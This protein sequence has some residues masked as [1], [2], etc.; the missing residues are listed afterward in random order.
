MKKEKKTKKMVKF[1]KAEIALSTLVTIILLV[2]GFVIILFLYYQINWVGNINK[3]VCHQSVVYRATAGEISGAASSYVPLKCK[4]DKICVTSGFWGGSCK[5]FENSKGVSTVKVKNKE[6]I[7]QL[8]AQNIVDC[9]SMMGEGRVSLFTQYWAQKVGVGGVYPSCVMCTRIAFDKVSLEKSGI[10]LSQINV[11]SYMMTH[12]VP[13]K[14]ISYYKYLVGESPVKLDG[15]DFV[16]VDATDADRVAAQ[17]FLE[18]NKVQ[19]PEFQIEDF[20]QDDP[21][22]VI[23]YTNQQ[24]KNSEISVMFMQITAPKYGDVL[25]TDATAALT[26]LGVTATTK[27]SAFAY[28]LATVPAG[29]TV[30]IGSKLYKGGQFLPKG[31]GPLKVGPLAYITA[32]LALTFGAIQMGDVAY[33]RAFTAGKCGDVMLK[34]EASDGCSVVRVVNYDAKSISNYCAAIESI[35]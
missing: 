13:D 9:W 25:M 11:M 30:T 34:G 27:P 8:I 12:A 28:R 18:K 3:E 4:T 26:F 32:F 6:Q 23:D 19:N 14:D 5:E 2:L 1:G 20:N 7:E 15:D 16:L 31:A 10:D 24:F 17:A 29:K 33:N 35:P 22:A 21:Q